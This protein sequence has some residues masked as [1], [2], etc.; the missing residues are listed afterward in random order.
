MI[1]IN[2]KKF[3]KTIK[4][5]LYEQD[6]SLS[7]LFLIIMPVI[8]LILF[9]IF[10]NAQVDRDELDFLRACQNELDLTLA[11]YDGQLWQEFGLWGTDISKLNQNNDFLLKEYK[12]SAYD[13]SF[14]I[15]SQISAESYLE[16]NSQLKK[17]ILRHMSYRAPA[18]LLDEL[19]TRYINYQNIG[20]QLSEIPLF[21]VD[22]PLIDTDEI[23]FIPDNLN[24]EIVEDNI[25]NLSEKDENEGKEEKE[26]LSEL[27]KENLFNAG[28]ELLDE[29]ITEAKNML[30]PIYEST[31]NNVPNNPLEPNAITNLAA[32]LDQLFV[33]Y[34]LPLVDDLLLSEYLFRYY[35]MHCSEL[36]Q[37]GSKQA[38][39]TPDGRFHQDL[40]N[41]GRKHE[42]EQIIFNKDQSDKAFATAKNSITAA[43]F[44]YHLMDSLSDQN[45]QAIYLTEASILCGSIALISLGTVI[46][47]PQSVSY[48]FMLIDVVANTNKD[49]NKVLSGKTMI[50]KLANGD[51]EINYKDF[52][53]IFLL[54]ISEDNLL[55]GMTRVRKNTSPKQFGITFNLKGSFD[56]KEITMKRSFSDFRDQDN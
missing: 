55:T 9:V 22:K 6:G 27:E 40:I 30:I 41:A 1:K 42:V 17:Q 23:L 19:K 14:S 7:L 54:T 46:I 35:T 47:E 29:T 48:L 8:M 49:V 2:N 21:P 25:K 12:K 37:N 20:S 38:L 39:T 43:C 44:A 5:K 53:R 32:G 50:I 51:I 34:D 33:N 52:M 3:I 45:K 13:D 56:N 16:E 11:D 31:G 15:S 24:N 4:Q 28:V 26:E 10:A 18:L 36:E